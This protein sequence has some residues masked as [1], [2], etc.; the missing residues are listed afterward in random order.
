MIYLYLCGKINYRTKRVYGMNGKS[1]TQTSH[2]LIIIVVVIAF[3]VILIWLYYG[4]LKKLLQGDAAALQAIFSAL[5]FVAI[6]VTLIYQ[7]QSLD[8]M[9][10]EVKIQ[11]LQQQHNLKAF[12]QSLKANA[13]TVNLTK[14]NLRAQFLVFWLEANQELYLALERT[15]NLMAK[16]YTLEE[17]KE[18]I[19]YLEK[20]NGHPIRPRPQIKYPTNKTSG[21][22]DRNE[23]T[24]DFTEDPKIPLIEAIKNVVATKQDW[25]KRYEARLAELEDIVSK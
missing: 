6:S 14:I 11:E 18:I 16:N 25:R 7:K 24:Y 12:Q 10:D 23:S 8:I 13:Q 3:A 2:M 22:V 5:A 1:N 4:G 20:I 21:C 15:Q 9:R 19:K 17:L